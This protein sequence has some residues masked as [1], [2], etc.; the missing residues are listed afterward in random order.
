MTQADS[1][2]IIMK[3]SKDDLYTC[4]VLDS[5]LRMVDDNFNKKGVSIMTTKPDGFIAEQMRKAELAIKVSLDNAEI[6][7]SLNLFNFTKVNVERGKVLL[8]FVKVTVDAGVTA[9]RAQQDAMAARKIAEIAA[10]EAFQGLAQVAKATFG[11]ETLASLGLSSAMPHASTAFLTA[12]YALFENVQKLPDVLA[13]LTIHGYDAQRLGRERDKI[14][15]YARADHA[16]E[17]AKGALQQ[18]TDTKNN[19]QKQLQDWFAE[20][21][22]VARV[23]LCDKKQ[24]L[25]DLS[26]EARPSSKQ[27]P[28][29]DRQPG[30]WL[31]PPASE[32]SFNTGPQNTKT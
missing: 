1:G 20:Y 21:R 32:A 31:N 26:I 9:G 6:L 22:K 13:K 3:L 15:A 7:K 25:E 28:H 2:G 17:A 11:S 14:S 12:G 4:T 27:R 30:K 10:R 29:N 23:A 5:F 24:L 16:H 19:A 18:V 8:D